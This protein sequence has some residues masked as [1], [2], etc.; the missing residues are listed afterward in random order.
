[1]LTLTQQD[2]EV[3]CRELGCGLPV[4]VLGRRWLCGRGGG[5]CGPEELSVDGNE[6]QIHS[7]LDISLHSKHNCSHDSDVG[8]VCAGYTGTQL[9][10][11][12]DSC[13]GR[14]ELQ[15]LRSGAQGNENTPVTMSHFIMESSCMLSINRIAED[16]LQLVELSNNL[17]NKQVYN[18]S[19][20]GVYMR[21]RVRFV[22][23]DGVLRGRWR[24]VLHAGLEKRVLAGR[25]GVRVC[26]LCGLGRQLGLWLCV[27]LLLQHLAI[28]SGTPAQMCV[29]EFQRSGSESSIWGTDSSPQASQLYTTREQGLSIS[30]LSAIR[31]LGSGGDCCRDGWSVSTVAHGGQCVMTCGA[32][33]MR[34][35]GSADSC[36]VGFALS[37]L[38][39]PAQVWNLGLGPIWLNEVECE[40][41]EMSLWNCR[42]QLCGEDECGHM[43][44]VGVM[45][46]EYKEIRL[47][48][49]CEGNL[50]VFYNGSWGNVCVNG[51]TEETASVVCRELNSGSSGSESWGRTRV[52]SAPNWLD[53][54]KCRKHDSTLWQCP[55]SPWGQNNCDNGNEVARITC[56]GR[57]VVLILYGNL[58]RM[59]RYLSPDSQ[60]EWRRGKLYHN[61]QWGFVCNDLWDIRDAQVVC[62]QLGCGPVNGSIVF[63]AGEGTVWLN[64]VKC[65]GNEIHLWDCPHSLKNHTDCS[66]RQH[67]GVTCAAHL[68]TET[69]VVFDIV[70]QRAM[71]VLY[72]KKRIESL[73][74][75]VK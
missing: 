56:S 64:R 1:M 19:S 50:E 59:C 42:F 43:E 60:A 25:L 31:L 71:D 46:S 9:M 11:G 68:L 70:Q 18:S 13:S 3:V 36:S 2:A 53:D 22:W 72:C 73:L 40:G 8:L 38:P 58:N 21:V 57:P 45:C 26:G 29:N 67:A 4:E 62:R 44:D 20:S 61:N 32:L 39:L 54:L 41:N 37:C 75:Y 52:E 74:A 17:I 16:H 48:E 47:T 51:M 35:C 34:Q 5:R 28:Q 49:G 7:C 30:C 27:K 10:N 65:T 24:V 15:C 69:D 23:R 33:K 12:L 14:V 63:G 55:S 66:H 6:S